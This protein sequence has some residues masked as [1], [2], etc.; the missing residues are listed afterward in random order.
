[1][2]SFH[3]II[4][5]SYHTEMVTHY[6]VPIQKY[7]EP[8]LVS[9]RRIRAWLGTENDNIQWVGYVKCVVKRIPEMR[10]Q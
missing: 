1:M 6:S 8:M 10:Y 7:F 2:M 4:L 3:L 5:A 9:W